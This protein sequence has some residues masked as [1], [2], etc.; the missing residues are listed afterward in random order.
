[1][2]RG[3]GETWHAPRR[4]PQQRSKC[5]GSSRRSTLSEGVYTQPPS[6][7][8]LAVGCCPFS[9]VG[10]VNTARAT[11][12]SCVPR[13]RAPRAAPPHARRSLRVMAALTSTSSPPPTHSTTRSKASAARDRLKESEELALQRALERQQSEATESP[14][15][16]NVR[17]VCVAVIGA[18]A[19][20]AICTALG[21]S[22]LRYEVAAV[23]VP[24]AEPA[25]PP[26]NATAEGRNWTRAFVQPVQLNE[27]RWKSRDATP[28]E[29][30]IEPVA[31]IAPAARAEPDPPPWRSRKKVAAPRGV[32]GVRSRAASNA[33]PDVCRH[34]KSIE[35]RQECR[36]SKKKV[37]RARRRLRPPPPPPLTASGPRAAGG[38]VASNRCAGWCSDLRWT[39]G[40][41]NVSWERRCK[42][43][44][45]CARCPQCSPPSAQNSSAT[46]L[47]RRRGKKKKKQR[48]AAKALALGIAAGRPSIA[49]ADT[50]FGAAAA[51]SAAADAAAAQ[52]F[53]GGF[54]LPSLP[55]SISTLEGHT[56]FVY[57]I[58]SQGGRFCAS[59]TEHQPWC[60][61]HTSPQLAL[62]AATASIW[63]PARLGC[64]AGGV[65]APRAGC[66]A[67]YPLPPDKRT[68]ASGAAPPSAQN[69]SAMAPTR[70]KGKG[71]RSNQKKGRR[72]GSRRSVASTPSPNLLR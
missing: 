11:P 45:N 33:T 30:E 61:G 23:R 29:E 39:T 1:M 27:S 38:V 32:G 15:V 37:E 71:K 4:R 48:G 20:A 63:L 60:E 46:A 3:A 49:V 28:P 26:S 22:T 31:E 5:G 24:T 53:R 35:A 50:A 40:Q 2:L 58:S 54:Q 62:S 25:G 19:V 13:T 55:P 52:A 66:P 41:H 36:H 47:T 43:W 64:C 18:L 6:F 42:A 12:A 59:S 14:D 56:C 65:L 8:R 44:R 10:G 51:A 69:S 21:A 7:N 67:E 17:I 9:R 68:G 34:L 16:Q 70:R 57:G 72:K